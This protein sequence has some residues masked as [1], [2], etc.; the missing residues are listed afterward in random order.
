[1]CQW[2]QGYH[3]SRLHPL[4]QGVEENGPCVGK[5]VS[6][7]IVGGIGIKF[8]LRFTSSSQLF[9]QGSTKY[10]TRVVSINSQPKKKTNG[11]GS[12]GT[13]L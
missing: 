13:S 1:M 6:H 5:R 11:L 8:L 3:Q 2:Q 4:Q 7:A 9:S 12:G 10:L